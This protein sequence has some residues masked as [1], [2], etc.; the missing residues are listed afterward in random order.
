MAV[1]IAGGERQSN[2]TFQAMQTLTQSTASDSS[3][4]SLDMR[5]EVS[6]LGMGTATGHFRNRYSL[7]TTGVEG[8]T[9]LI[10]SSATGEAKVFVPTAAGR[11]SVQASL[12][13]VP[14]ATAV[15]A[16]WASATGLWQFAADGDFLLLRFFNGLWYVQNG[17][18]VTMTTGT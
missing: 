4:Q 1:V 6:T 13:A 14:S 15:D 11:M 8:Q 12:L 16:I 5:K 2:D 3:F 10:I 17:K 7:A 9:K 18:G